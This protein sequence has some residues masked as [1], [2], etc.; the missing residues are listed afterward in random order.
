MRRALLTGV[1][2]A[3][4]AAPPRAQAAEPAPL[5]AA[6]AT[7]LRDTVRPLG[8]RT[9]LAIVLGG[10][11]L[12]AACTSFEDADASARALQGAPWDRLSDVGN[13][14]GELPVISSTAVLLYAAGRWSGHAPLRDAGFDAMRALCV[15][16]AAV[17]VLKLSVKRTR[18]DGGRHSFPSGHTAAAMAMAPVITRH[19]GWRFGVPAHAL[20][21]MAGM[22]RIE[23][24]RHHLSDVV[25]GGTIGLT[26]GLAARQPRRG[27]P[28]SVGLLLDEDRIGCVL[29][30]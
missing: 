8:A 20:A 17:G 3:L 26:A 18:P 19:L 27:T 22:G 7:W 25:W 15:S 28:T 24:R 6:S 4:L 16:G 5:S 13:A 9:S 23:D 29:H 30:F 10:A 2:A 1:M 21:L 11:A 14:Y 12:G